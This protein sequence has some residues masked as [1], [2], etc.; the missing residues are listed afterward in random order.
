[1]DRFSQLQEECLVNCKLS[2]RPHAGA[3]PVTDKESRLLVGPSIGQYQQ[4]PIPAYVTHNGVR[5][6]FHRIAREDLAG[7][8]PLDQLADHEVLIAPGLIYGP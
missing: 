7:E 2:A 8:I 3:S 5:L 1:M 4:Q 6:P